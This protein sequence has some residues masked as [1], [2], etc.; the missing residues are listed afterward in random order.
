MTAKRAA[1]RSS[2]SSSRATKACRRVFSTRIRQVTAMIPLAVV[3]RPT[4]AITPAANTTIAATSVVP[5]T[6][7]RL[8]AV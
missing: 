6:A 8:A 7:R 1:A 3:S 5:S 2:V 4:P